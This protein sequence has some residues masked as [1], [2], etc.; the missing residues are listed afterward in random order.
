MS[1]PFLL[2]LRADSTGIKDLA[3][4]TI[5]ENG[6]FTFTNAGKFGGKSITFDGTNDLY[7]N[8]QDIINSDEDY[9]IS[10]WMKLTSPLNNSTGIIGNYPLGDLSIGDWTMYYD[11]Y[12]TYSG[13]TSVSRSSTNINIPASFGINLTTPDSEWHHYAKVRHNGRSKLY[14]DGSVV[15]VDV[16]WNP[17]G[18]DS[19][20][21]YADV[22]TLS[23][24][25]PIYVGKQLRLSNNFI[26]QLDDICIIKG[27]ALWTEDF[28]PPTTYLLLNEVIYLSGQEA[29]GINGSGNFAKLNNNYSAMTSAEKIAMFD[30]TAGQLP[31]IA[32][33][34]TLT[35]P[36]KAVNYYNKNTQPTCKV[37]AIPTPQTVTPKG[38]ISLKNYAKLKGVSITGATSGNGSVKVAVTKDNNTYQIYD[39]TNLAWVDINIADIDTDGM[40]LSDVAALT[41]TEWAAYDCM[42][43]GIGFAYYLE[44]ASTSDT[45]YTDELTLNVELLGELKS[46]VKGTD[47]NYSYVSNDVLQVKLYK[48]GDFRINYNPGES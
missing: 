44:M 35:M 33:L 39:S 29:W 22:S 45:A 1:S 17:I 21:S 34:K 18:V 32:E 48:N 28:T 41:T 26:G 47:Y 3:G 4:N 11:A 25:N 37:T 27:K 14:I 30:A 13:I 7:F 10:F 36:I 15:T 20:G 31:T 43:S 8:M 16:P 42:S 6:T 12:D 2:R 19:S 9:T 38:R 40:S 23:N 46:L 5:N 24:I